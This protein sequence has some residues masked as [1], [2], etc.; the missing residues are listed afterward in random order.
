MLLVLLLLCTV[1]VLLLWT[2]IPLLYLLLCS[3]YAD[4]VLLFVLLLSLLLL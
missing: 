4:A 1:V 3:C 2:G